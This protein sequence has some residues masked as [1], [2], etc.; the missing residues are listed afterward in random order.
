MRDRVTTIRKMK[1]INEQEEN[2]TDRNEYKKRS[3]TGLNYQTK[4]PPWWSSSS[5]MMWCR[6]LLVRPHLPP[7]Q[8]WY[9][10]E[11]LKILSLP[12][13]P[14]SLCR[15]EGFKLFRLEARNVP[16]VAG[17]NWSVNFNEDVWV[18]EWVLTSPAPVPW[19]SRWAPSFSLSFIIWFIIT[20]LAT[21]LYWSTVLAETVLI[22]T[23]ISSTVIEAHLGIDSCV[24]AIEPV[25][26]LNGTHPAHC[27]SFLW[28]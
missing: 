27:C 6:L 3:H 22:R 12:S 1:K 14:K 9:W 19:V 4:I 23:I 11:H 24:E 25:D 28:P 7:C 13:H 21:L 15:K 2:Q 8:V 26:Y 16:T 18:S 20:A 10:T 5:E 17:T